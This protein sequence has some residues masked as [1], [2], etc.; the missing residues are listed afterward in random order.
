MITREL[1]AK[2]E[3]KLFDGKAIVVVGA[4]Q[5]GKTTLF[6]E[7]LRNRPE[8]IL[9]LNLDEADARERSVV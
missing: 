4:R 1:Q 8:K 9:R 5:V 7:V 2:I 6:N 3:Q